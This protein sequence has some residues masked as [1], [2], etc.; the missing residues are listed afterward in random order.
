MEEKFKVTFGD[1]QVV[2][3]EEQLLNFIKTAVIH[4][5]DINNFTVNRIK[6]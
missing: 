2:Y 1:T 5:K 4:N 6:V 3:T